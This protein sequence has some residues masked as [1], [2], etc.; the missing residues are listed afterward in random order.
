VI[1][2]TFITVPKIFTRGALKINKENYC[3]AEIGFDSE[4]LN[5]YFKDKYLKEDAFYVKE[6]FHSNKIFLTDFFCRL[7]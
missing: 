4:K 1:R 6:V 7:N 3:M 2:Q 5:I